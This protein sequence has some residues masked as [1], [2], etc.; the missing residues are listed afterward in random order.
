MTFKAVGVFSVGAKRSQVERRRLRDGD[1]P[2]ASIQFWNFENNF[3]KSAD[4]QSVDG[5]DECEGASDKQGR[6]PRDTQ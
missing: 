5:G 4:Y 1:L 6:H 3:S 2:L